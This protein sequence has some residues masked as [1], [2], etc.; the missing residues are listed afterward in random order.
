M[1]AQSAKQPPSPPPSLPRASPSR[2]RPSLLPF[3]ER[4]EGG[5]YPIITP[6]LS[7][8]AHHAHPDPSPP[9]HHSPSTIPT[10]HLPPLPPPMCFSLLRPPHCP[11]YHISYSAVPP[12]M[13]TILVNHMSLHTA[14]SPL[15]ARQ[16]RSVQV[17][18]RI[19]YLECAKEK[20]ELHYHHQ[21]IH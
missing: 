11:H 8:N 10:S 1:K 20:K 18:L 14:L 6:I 13:R 3:W 15:Y 16:D 5:G 2:P 19:D 7:I 4:V 12:S 17:G 9:H 21:R